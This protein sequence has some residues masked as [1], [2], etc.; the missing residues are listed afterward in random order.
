M[1]GAAQSAASGL[2]ARLKKETASRH[3][4]IERVV[5]L[6]DPRFDLVGYRGYLSAMYAFHE[7]IEEVLATLPGVRDTL[8]DFD[9]RRKLPLLARDLD[10]LAVTRPTEPAPL[11]RLPRL[12]STARALGV[13]YVL[14]GSTLGGRVI[15]PH[16]ESRLGITRASG[17]AYLAS[18]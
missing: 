7:P 18:Y 6:L 12:D 16:L 4:A 11:S 2:M 17:G 9:E 8:P 13:L 10:M 5:P 3:A 14:E 15:S 1:A